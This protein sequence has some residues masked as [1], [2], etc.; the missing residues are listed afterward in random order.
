LAAVLSPSV[1]EIPLPPDG[2]EALGEDEAAMEGFVSRGRLPADG[3]VESVDPV[4]ELEDVVEVVALDTLPVF[5]TLA[6]CVSPFDVELG[7]TNPVG[8]IEPQVSSAEQFSSS[9]WFPAASET[10][11]EITNSHMNVGI[12]PVNTPTSGLELFEAQVQS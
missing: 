7:S 11:V 5:N 9:A 2:T 8:F 4:P 6:E 3:D 10:H 1:F 12:V